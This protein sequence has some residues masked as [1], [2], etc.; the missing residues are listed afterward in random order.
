MLRR[1][2]PN[3]SANYRFTGEVIRHAVWLYFRLPLSL[4]MV[5][6]ILAARS[7]LVSGSSGHA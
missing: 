1:C 5:E 7:I 6:E 3:P 4:S 2:R